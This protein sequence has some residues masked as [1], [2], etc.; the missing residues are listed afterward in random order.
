M[1]IENMKGRKENSGYQRV[2]NNNAMGYLFSKV[3]A[4]VIS[5]GSELERIILSQSNIIDNLDTFIENAT[6]NNLEN[7]V[8]VCP[9]E[10]IKKSTYSVIGI[11]PDLL[12]F[13]VQKK[14]ICK[15]IELKD[16]DSFDTK[17]S[18]SERDN[19]I[20]FSTE[21]GAKIPFVTE[22]FV[23]CFNQLDK[24]MI[25][26]GFKGCFDI[27]HIMTGEEL[28]QILNIDYHSIIQNRQK[29]AQENFEYFLTELLKIQEVKNFVK[30][31]I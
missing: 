30:T 6:D 2:F 3:Q 27:S 17:K 16:G 1:K 21:F 14:R 7:G 29:D 26:A 11:E 31:I 28:C 15:V 20:K 12:I 8:F 5:N 22:Y 19:L 25:K 4:T 18:K 9:K 10:I 24:E 23:C 13:I